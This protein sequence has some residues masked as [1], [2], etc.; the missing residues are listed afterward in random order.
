[1]KPLPTMRT[2]ASA[3]VARSAINRL[4]FPAMSLRA[5]T[6]PLATR[7]MPRLSPKRHERES[8]RATRTTMIAPCGGDGVGTTMRRTTLILLHPRKLPSSVTVAGFGW[9]LF[10]GLILL[11]V[12]F[13][14]GNR[15]IMA[16]TNKPGEVGGP[17][18]ARQPGR[19]PERVEP[20]KTRRN[21]RPYRDRARASL[22]V[23]S[24]LRSFLSGHRVSAAR[25]GIR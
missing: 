6:S 18:P 23:F 5:R 12:A 4:S 19:Q 20:K 17:P 2:G 24:G 8:L 13:I 25:R 22:G 11:G 15:F 21:W 10:G 9:I 14:L 1:M 3:V 7:T 16:E